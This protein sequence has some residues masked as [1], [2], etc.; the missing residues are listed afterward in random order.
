MWDLKC[1]DPTYKTASSLGELKETVRQKLKQP[2][3]VEYEFT[4]LRGEDIIA[5]EDGGRAV[6]GVACQSNLGR[7]RLR[8]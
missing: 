2:A 3:N 4:H 6:S 8:L 5:L 1:A 7:H